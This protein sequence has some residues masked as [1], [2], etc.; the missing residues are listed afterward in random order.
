MRVFLVVMC[1]LVFMSSFAYAQTTKIGVVD[2]RRV[3]TGSKKGKSTFSAVESQ[4]GPRSKA[5]ET[6]KQQ[7]EVMEQDFIKNAAVMNEASRKQKAE[8]ID[9]MK[10]DFTRSLED[11]QYELKKKDYELTQQ[12]MGEIEGILKS[13]GQSGGYTMIIDSS[14]LIY[15]SQA[16]DIT[17]QVI[18]AYDAK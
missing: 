17:N 15:Y 9:R 14:V 16:T 5:L 12:I 18:Q 2:L 10:K 6:K 1:S 4:F 7:L 3:V 11:F 13:I 8:Q